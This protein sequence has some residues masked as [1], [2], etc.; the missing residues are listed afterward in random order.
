MQSIIIIKKFEFDRYFEPTRISQLYIV[1]DIVR[2]L[3][4]C[5]EILIYTF[6]IIVHL[7]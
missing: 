4:V 2:Y 6:N 1:F 5:Y 3:L 7:W